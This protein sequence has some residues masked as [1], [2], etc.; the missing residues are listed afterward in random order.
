MSAEKLNIAEELKVVGEYQAFPFFGGPPMTSPKYNTP[1]TPKENFD[2]FMKGEK[3]LWQPNGLDFVT[4][5]PRVVPDNVARAFVFDAEPLDSLKE[6]GGIDWFGVEWEYVPKVN[7]SMVRPGAPLKVPNV[8]EWE[9]YITFPNLDEMDWEG[10]AEKNNKFL[11]GDRVKIVWVMNG[12]YERLISFME[13][14]NAAI[15]LVDEDMKAGVH[16]L[17]D[18]LAN[19]YDEV[20]EKIK[21]YY[22]ADT[23]YFH[24]DWGS[25]RSPFFSIRTVREMLVPYLKRICDSAHKRDMYLDLHSCGKVEKLVPAMIEAG[26]DIWSGQIMNDKLAVAK[27]YGD[28]IKVSVAPLVD[29]RTATPEEVFEATKELMET[30]GPV[31][32]SVLISAGMGGSPATYEYIY[33]KTREEFAK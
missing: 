33:T 14:E 13:F 29:R 19:F 9:K 22:D 21:K 26:V 28:K 1:I 18:A 6:G 30:Y 25:Q 17:F 15:A 27:E 8:A 31:L 4:L 23:I 16:R 5:V 3:P 2:R 24:D 10:S 32:N 20:F 11:A 12:L 7:G